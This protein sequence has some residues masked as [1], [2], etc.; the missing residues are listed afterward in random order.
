MIMPSSGNAAAQPNQPY[1]ALGAGPL[2]SFLWKSGDEQQGWQYR[3]NLFR[4]TRHSGQVSQSFR[5]ADLAKLIRL[6]QLLA[7]TLADDG[8]LDPELRDELTQL[9][10]A[11][12][13]AK[14]R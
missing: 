6:C 10:V 11:L 3:F 5:P 14:Q 9:A 7:V 1:A 4:Q 8:C 13:N 12:N 2:T